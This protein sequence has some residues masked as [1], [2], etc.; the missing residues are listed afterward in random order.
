MQSGPQVHSGLGRRGTPLEALSRTERVVAF[1]RILL[2]LGTLAVILVDPKQPSLWPAVGYLL[3]TTYLAFAVALFLLLR[4]AWL[5]Q[6][7]IGLATTIADVAWVALITVFTERG[8]SPYFLLHV[9][10][11]ASASVR[12]GMAGAIPVTLVLAVLYPLLAASIALASDPTPFALNRA[13]FVRPLYLLGVGYLLGYLGEHERRSKRKLALLLDL[14]S[15][16]R[17]RVQSVI[18]LARL[19]RRALRFFDAQ[20]GLLVLRDPESGRWFAWTMTATGRR[21]RLTLRIAE[22]DPTPL[23]FCSESEAFFAND[24]RPAR[25]SALCYDVLTGGL[26]RRPIPDDVALPASNAQALMA[27]PVLIERELRGRVLL[28]RTSRRKFTRDDLEFLLVVVG[29]AAA[30]LE[31]ARLQEKAEE[32][33]VVEER[34]RI[35]RD[36]HDGFIQALA[37]IDLRVEAARLLLQK[38][39]ARVPKALEDLHG[40][41]ST[42][43]REVRHYLTVLRSASRQARDLGSTLDRLAAEFSIRERIRVHLA[44]PSQDPGLP[45]STT[46]ELTQIVREALQNAVRHGRATQAVVK[47]AARPSHLYLVVRD[48]GR[49]FANGHGTVDGDGFLR[50]GET[51]WS[52]RER[53]AALGGS[54]AVWSRPGEGLEVSVLI[55]LSGRPPADAVSIDEEDAR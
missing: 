50:P 37:G 19:L 35:A 43:Y 41:V 34:A 13:H 27:A 46:Y 45:A 11:V 29:Q 25:R 23:G 16:A 6:E 15:P 7:R 1:C 9:F 53:T 3:L 47:V 49:G 32:I 48:N 17:R 51:P 31:R 24:L 54:L 55:P 52:I 33:A 14:S 4:S 5:P 30:A 28:G 42:G 38:D 18:V 36:L 44:R 10:V 22:R 8:P 20:V 39:P 21:I 40:V 26:R 12:W 2:A